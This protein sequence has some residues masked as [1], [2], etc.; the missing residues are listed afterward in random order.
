MN[1]DTELINFLQRSFG[2]SL[3][4]SVQEHALFFGHGGG[5]NGKGTTIE[6]IAGILGDY[7]RTAPMEVFTASPSDRHPTELAMLQGSRFV[8]AS[9]TEE[10]R[11]WAESKIK[12]MTGGDKIAARFMRGDFFEYNP[13]FKLW[14]TGNHKPGLRS[15]DEA[16]RRRFNLIP[17]TVTIPDAERDKHLFDK[18]KE[19]W[20]GILS[21]MIEGCLVWQT[22]GLAPPTAVRDATNEYLR[23][24]DALGL[25][26]AERCI[27]DPVSTGALTSRLFEDW[28]R[29]AE[30]AREY[31]ISMRKF[32]EMLEARSEALGIKKVSDLQMID[33][34]HGRGFKGVRLRYDGDVLL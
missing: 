4:G 18:L 19:E 31:Q 3:T 23:S 13:Q 34:K 15:V 20:P 1:G 24:E 25:W 11:R 7:A 14:L 5:A 21:W 32:S 12:Q 8:T 29:W 6:T 33:G 16:I 9:E 30:R 10:G 27:A 28:K 17:F 2:Y 26:F 22:M